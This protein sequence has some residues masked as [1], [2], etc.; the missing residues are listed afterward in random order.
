MLQTTG[1]HILIH[2]FN[3]NEHIDTQCKL[4]TY[5]DNVH[6]TYHITSTDMAFVTHCHSGT[7]DIIYQ[8][9][10]TILT[11]N[12]CYLESVS[13]IVVLNK[14]GIFISTNVIAI[15]VSQLFTTSSIQLGFQ[16]HATL[17]L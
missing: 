8:Q 9:K 7:K 16:S 17:S 11:S 12:Q 10:H 13:L 14:T 5:V 15:H 3:H 1:R 4:Q 6:S 2:N